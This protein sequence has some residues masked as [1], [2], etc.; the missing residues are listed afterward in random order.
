MRVRAG[1]SLL[2]FCLSASGARAAGP[3]V[4][5]VPGQPAL[6]LSSFD[7]APF[8]Y[9]TDEFFVSGMAS[10]YKLAGPA[11]ADG[12]WNALV[13]ETAPYRWETRATFKTPG[14]YVLRCVAHDGALAATENVTVVVTQ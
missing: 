3:T 7:L 8:G 5:A 4:V 9:A 14:E 12:M 6:L 1:V 11:S 13:A 10:S 2:A